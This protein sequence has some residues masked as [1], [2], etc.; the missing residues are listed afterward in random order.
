MNTVSAQSKS[1]DNQC[2]SSAVLIPS[3][4]DIFPT[5]ILFYFC[6]PGVLRVNTDSSQRIFPRVP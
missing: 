1:K 4:K 2:C 3:C 6:I 5:L